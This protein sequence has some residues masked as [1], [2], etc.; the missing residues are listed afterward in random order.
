MRIEA[1]KKEYIPALTAMEKGIFGA[2]AWSE[3][4]FESELTNPSAVFLCAVENGE[5]K[6]CIAMNDALG[7]GFISKVMVRE[8]CRRQGLGAALLKKLIAVARERQM[9]ELTLEVRA[10]NVPAISL[11][12]SFGFQNLGL[13]RNFYHDPTE[14][15]VIMTKAL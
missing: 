4:G 11:Y 14:D 8:D 5:V 12:E 2:S 13:R 1:L 15:A 10:S 3:S 7:Q 9:F 6:G